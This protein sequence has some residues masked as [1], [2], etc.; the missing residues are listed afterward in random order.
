MVPVLS[1]DSTRFPA[2]DTRPGT[3]LIAIGG[4][5]ST[6]R[7]LAAYRQGIFPWYAE[8]DPILWHCPS[9]RFVLFPGDLRIHK[10]FRSVL[11]NHTYTLTTDQAFDRVIRAC[12]TIPRPGQDGTWIHPEM[13]RAYSDLHALGHARSVEVWDG[14]DLVGGLYGVRLG[15]VFFGESMFSAVSDAS[16]LALH[17]L[18]QDPTIGVI[19]CQ[20]HT[21]HLER[22]GACNVPGE[23][24]QD[25]LHA[26][27]GRN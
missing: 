4:D 2:V 16:K 20:V 5:L 26:H 25:L 23:R 22:M 11:R 21:D 3:S 9:P 27:L 7:L 10:S 17:H 14:D 19:D 13:I 1:T 6:D 18:C 8:G 24:F 15:G 12:A